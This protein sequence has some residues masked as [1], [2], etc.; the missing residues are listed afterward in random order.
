MFYKSG[1]VDLVNSNFFV[2][3]H[4]QAY[5]N[6]DLVDVDENENVNDLKKKLK[7][8]DRNEFIFSKIYDIIN[9]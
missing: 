2:Q 7:S 8:A 4:V 3:V 9:T 1:F 5:A 6:N